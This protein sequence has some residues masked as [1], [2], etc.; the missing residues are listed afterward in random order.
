MGLQALVRAGIALGALRPKTAIILLADLFTKRDWQ[1]QPAIELWD[2]LDPSK[3]V[4]DNSDKSPEEVIAGIQSP[5][6]FFN[7]KPELFDNILK[8]VIEW[9]LILTDKFGAYYNWIFAQGLVWGLS[10]PEE[11]LARYEEQRQKHLKNLPDMLSHGLDVY[12]PETFEEFTDAIEESVNAFQ[13]EIHPF[14]EIPRELLSL[15]AIASRLN[16]T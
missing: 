16:S 15:P 5:M 11:A 4:A 6:V 9:K 12:P 3:Q 14:A 13:D 1:R 2:A 7:N 10:H 8:D